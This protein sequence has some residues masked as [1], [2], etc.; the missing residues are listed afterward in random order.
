LLKQSDSALAGKQREVVD[1]I[2][3]EE[4]QYI[5][6]S[7][8]ELESKKLSSIYLLTIDEEP[9][10]LTKKIFKKL[11]K[12]ES[13]EAEADLTDFDSDDSCVMSQTD[14]ELLDKY[15]MDDDSKLGIY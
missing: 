15:S 2:N 10:K 11:N 12:L 1:S 5:T 8:I 3:N 7:E 6:A 13:I 4:K 9:F 14:K